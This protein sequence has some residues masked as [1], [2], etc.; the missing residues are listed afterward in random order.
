MFN[1]QDIHSP[2]R[3]KRK[4]EKR[5]APDNPGR[6]PPSPIPGNRA[7]SKRDVW[8]DKIRS[9]D[10]RLEAKGGDRARRDPQE[11]GLWLGSNKELLKELTLTAPK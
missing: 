3:K 6:I 7:T 10:K 4:E 11:R 9:Q 5:P 8:Q 1:C 2:W